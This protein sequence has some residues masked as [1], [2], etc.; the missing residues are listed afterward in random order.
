ML[1]ITSCNNDDDDAPGS[2]ERPS[3][4]APTGNAVQVGQTTTL[5]FNVSAPGNIASVTVEAS[6]GT[7]TISNEADVKGKAT[8]TV[9]VSY[10][11][12]A[13]AGSH[14]VTLTVTDAQSTAKTETGIA[15]V[16]V[17]T[18]PVVTV[19]EVDV[20]SSP[21]GVGTT[22][23]TAD[24]VYILRGFVFVNEGQTL[25]I[26]P[27]T[28]IK[29][30]PGQGSGAS[31][32][33][34]ARGGKIMA[35]GTEENP[36]IFT[37]L[38][39]DIEDL[40]DIAIDERKMWGGLILLGKAPINHANGETL[41]EGIPETEARGIYGGDDPE[42]NSGVLKYISIRHGGT[43]IGANNEI[44]GLTMGGIGR[45]TQI[46]YIEV[47]GNDD[48]GFEWFGGTVN[49]SYLASIYNQDDAYDWDF[50]YRGQNQFWFAFQNPDLAISDKGMELDGAH[51]GNLSTTAFSQPTVFNMTL[52][53]HAN[54]AGDQTAF[55]MTEGN[56]GF[57][58]NSIITNFRGGINLNEVGAAGA[59]TRDRLDNGDLAFQN[60]IF[61]NLGGFT[62]LDEVAEGYA[63]LATHLA[64][65]NNT[66]GD[67]GLVNITT[68]SLNPSPA[69]DGAAYQDLYEIPS[70]AVDGFTYESVNYKGAFG[71]TNWLLGWSA[72][73]AYG[74]FE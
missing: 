63:P 33:I 58:R 32:L 14:T 26:E 9:N 7:A 41:I 55:F 36:I 2:Q 25:T 18:E 16:N 35:E 11:A 4:I 17:T 3:I 42:D 71:D 19:P 47:F 66:Y 43:N 5:A 57:I 29:G 23:W 73:D 62:T 49:T 74:L 21:D 37:G 48:D 30:Q 65:N 69:A 45:G 20:Y 46:S 31:A 22:T 12:P 27:G 28:V 6:A 13:E 68:G 1:G 15:T 53:G 60:N 38:E 64:D 67:P 56:G 70:T 24:N 51:S 72:A 50:G 54:T 10:V 34:V 8:G 44:N 40:E 61:W 59:T 39:D 52:I